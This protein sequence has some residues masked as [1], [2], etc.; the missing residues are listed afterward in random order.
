MLAKIHHS[1]LR[2]PGKHNICI[3]AIYGFCLIAAV[4]GF[5]CRMFRR[6]RDHFRENLNIVDSHPNLEILGLSFAMLD[7]TRSGQYTIRING[8]WRICSEWPDR[9]P[10]PVNVE[11]VDYH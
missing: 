5:P 11:I 7:V 10:G 3:Y 1:L 6:G 9:I 8:Q 2:V 4:Q